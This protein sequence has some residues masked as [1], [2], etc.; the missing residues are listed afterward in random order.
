[1]HSFIELSPCTRCGFHL[2][3]ALMRQTISAGLRMNALL[4]YTRPYKRYS[5]VK[6]TRPESKD[7][8]LSAESASPYQPSAAR[9]D[10]ADTGS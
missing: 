3:I 1:M 4:Y 5:R 8:D 2:D 6:G 10:I 7:G 9:W